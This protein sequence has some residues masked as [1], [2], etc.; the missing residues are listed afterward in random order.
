MSEQIIIDPVK[1]ISL[2]GPILAQLGKLVNASMKHWKD[3]PADV[4]L[5]LG[6]ACALMNK[7]VC[8]NAVDEG[9][10]T[11]LVPEKQGEKTLGERSMNNL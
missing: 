9:N 10:K 4:K 7:L 6:N 2:Q 5:E 11:G 3:A 8:S 1:V